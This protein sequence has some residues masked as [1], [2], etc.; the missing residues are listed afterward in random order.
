MIGFPGSNIG[1]G[2]TVVPVEHLRRGQ[3]RQGPQ[4][5]VGDL[6]RRHR[7]HPGR[8]PALC[9][10]LHVELGNTDRS[11]NGQGP[12]AIALG[13]NAGRQAS[14]SHRTAPRPT[15][16]RR[17]DRN[18]R[19]HGDPDRPGARARHLLRSPSGPDPKASPSLPT[20][21]APTSPTRVPSSPGQTGA[22][23]STVTP[24]DL[25]TGKALPAILVGHAPVAVAISP[26]GSTHY[27]ANVNSGS[28]S[29]IDLSTDKAGSPISVQGGPVSIAIS[30]VRSHYRLVADG[31]ST[32]SKTGNVTPISLTSDTAGS[33]IAVGNEPSVNRRQPRRRDRLGRLLPGEPS[34]PSIPR[35]RSRAFRSTFPVART[36][37]PCVSRSDF[38]HHT[39]TTP[40]KKKKG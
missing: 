2:H 39:T 28:V 4:C 20:G 9:D 32:A 23:G 37:S 15:S 8:E 34:C 29:P 13:A 1:L 5:A 36:R 19:R 38:Q 18:P 10:Q 21:S 40:S 3:R 12:P 35:H 30:A 14:P 16:R 25:T 11:R 6:P 17:R 26:N 22:I 24:V 7:Y 31:V 27:V 33:P